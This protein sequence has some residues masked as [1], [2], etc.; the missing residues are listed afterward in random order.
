MIIITSSGRGSALRGV[1]RKGYDDRP[2]GGQQQGGVGV[3]AEGWVDNERVCVC[4]I[5]STH[6]NLWFG[7][8]KCNYGKMHLGH[9]KHISDEP[10]VRDQRNAIFTE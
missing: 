1:W 6:E 3:V 2:E 5:C 4:N 7:C 8:L 10:I 9:I